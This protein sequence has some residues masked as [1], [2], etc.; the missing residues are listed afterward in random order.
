M[1]RRHSILCALLLLLSYA[2]MVFAMSETLKIGYYYG[3]A[4]L[5]PA[6]VATQLEYNVA[7]QLFEG[8]TS[9]TQE[10]LR[11]EPGMAVRWEITNDGATYDFYLR[12]DA[13]WSDGVAISCD[14]FRASWLRTLRP[15]TNSPQAALLFYISNA[16]A[17]NQGVK[18]AEQ[19]GIACSSTH[20]LRVTLEHP[21]P[22]FLQLTSLPAYFPVPEHHLQ[23]IGADW[24]TS[25]PIVGNGAFALET[26]SSIQMRLK[27][28]EHYW[29]H[30][31]IALDDVELRFF[32]KEGTKTALRAYLHGE[33]DWLAW[34]PSQDVIEM[35]NSPDLLRLPS[36]STYYYL[37]NVSHPALADPHVRKALYL[38]LR[39]G[40]ICRE[41][42]KSGDL[43][44]FGLIPPRIPGY[45]NYPGEREDVARAR[46]LLRKAGFPDGNGFP[47]LT[48]MIYKCIEH[49]M[50]AE[51]I[52]KIWQ[53]ELNIQINI[54][55]QEGMEFWTRLAQRKYEI[56]CFVW[57]GDYLDPSTFL[58]LFEDASAKTNTTGW[59]NEEYARL[60]RQS[61]ALPNINERF[62]LY[63]RAEKII[64]D[65][66]PI[67][68]ILHGIS[69][70]L[71]KPYVT[72]IVPNLLNFYPLK[73][74]RIER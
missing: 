22:F 33:V 31:A 50:I 29:A 67:V 6:F 41:T 45:A 38:A 9:F 40:N 43:P 1:K 73:T 62:R 57:S 16:Q 19:V 66:T 12:E 39:R 63:A 68:P 18:T 26:W 36:F 47:S 27:K 46:D 52:Q 34:V 49:Q 64:I 51:A 65:E 17:Y 14:T 28:N 32:H 72:G 35:L 71:V 15:E 30:N 60:L 13:Q 37:L 59:Q 7:M 11:P 58:E 20:L 42:L 5:D 56:A 55:I 53:D 3:V 4:T 21:S 23:Q 2:P 10:D 74:V 69:L 44:A 48:I 8:L 70:H 54:E 24:G 25:A 61:R